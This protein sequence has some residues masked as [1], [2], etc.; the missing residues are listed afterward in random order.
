MI[1]ITR[2]KFSAKKV[3]LQKVHSSNWLEELDS[4]ETELKA[5]TRNLEKIIV[6]LNRH[7][8]SLPKAEQF[9]NQFLIQQKNINNLKQEI[10]AILQ[11]GK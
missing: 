6:H 4:R 11:L 3:P 2:L 8:A 10:Q 9:Q 1:D 7:P 5:C